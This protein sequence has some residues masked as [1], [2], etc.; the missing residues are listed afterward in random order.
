MQWLLKYN[1]T[2]AEIKQYGIAWCMNRQLLVLIQNTGY[3]QARN[4]GFGNIKY[5]SQG[6]KPNTIYGMGDTLVLVEDILSAIK[7]ARLR[8]DYCAM[9]V[10]G[11]TLSFESEQSLTKQFKTIFVW[12]DRDKALNALRI[13]RRLQQKGITSR[14]IVTD[15]DPKEFDKQTIKEYL[16]G[17]N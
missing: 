13:K 15:L 11:S 17:D 16:D 8:D 4:F 9:P 5:M 2:P 14:I 10:L 12:L 1:I 6:K 7:I 3:W